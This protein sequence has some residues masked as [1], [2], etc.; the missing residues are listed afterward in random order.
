MARGT[1]E[2]MHKAKIYNTPLKVIPN[3]AGPGAT[4]TERKAQFSCSYIRTRAGSGGYAISSF[5]K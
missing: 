5:H 2:K 1:E 4:L 3:T